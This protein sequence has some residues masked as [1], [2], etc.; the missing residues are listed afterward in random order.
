MRFINKT[1]DAMNDGIEFDEDAAFADAGD[2]DGGSDTESDDYIEADMDLENN[3]RL[4]NADCESEEE[5]E[6]GG[7]STSEDGDLEIEM[8]IYAEENLSIDGKKTDVCGWW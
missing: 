4:D 3:L 7:S 6:G 5:S 2:D 8:E 1:L